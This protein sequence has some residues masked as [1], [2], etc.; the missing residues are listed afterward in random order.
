MHEDHALVET[1]V[2]L[3]YDPDYPLYIEAILWTM[4]GSSFFWALGLPIYLI[5][6]YLINTYNG[7]LVIYGFWAE[8]TYEK[9]AYCQT[10]DY[11]R[12]TVQLEN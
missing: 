4:L 10:G 6:G 12:C 5:A 8:M 1:E 9:L 7:W 11:P 2:V 3:L